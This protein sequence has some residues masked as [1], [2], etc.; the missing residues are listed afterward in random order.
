M[1]LEPSVFELIKGDETVFEKEP[2]EQL[3]RMGELMSYS[4]KGFW[5]CMDN[6]REMNMLEQLYAKGVAPWQKW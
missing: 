2:M 1:V 6:V 5:Q 3:V 4:H